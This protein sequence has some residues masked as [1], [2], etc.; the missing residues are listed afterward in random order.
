MVQEFGGRV[1]FVVE[2]YGDS[3]LAKRFGV[4]RYPA[5]FAGDVLVATPKDFGF[6]GK[7]EGAGEGRYTPIKSAASQERFRADLSRIVRLLL[8]GKGAEARAQAATADSGAPAAALPEISLVDLEGRPL[9]KADL[10]GRV[11]FVEF[12]ATWC[13]PCR[14]T[15]SWLGQLEQRYGDRIAVVALAVESDEAEVRKVAAQLGFPFRWAMATPEV[16]RGFGDVSVLPT[17]HLF[18]PDG[19][20]A[21]TFYGATPDL[22]AQAEAK[23]TA[24]VRPR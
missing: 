1:R 7:G 15:L 12:W 23:L 11:V 4:T 2:N 8:A 24:L 3:A 17:L 20:G 18:G 5:I 14:G 19:R 21:A 13:A 6:Y 22:H 9:S 10:A 16:A